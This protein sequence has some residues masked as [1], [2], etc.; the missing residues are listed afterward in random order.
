MTEETP[1]SGLRAPIAQMFAVGAVASAL[2]IGL[3]LLIDWWPKQGST[4]S[5]DIDTLYDVLIIVTVP[6]FVMVT[7]IV[8]FSCLTFRMRPGEE[9][10]DGPPTHGNTRLEVIWTTIPAL[11]LV[12]MC[13]YAY[14]VL[15]DIE[16]A[17]AGE[18][19]VNV[20]G[21]QFTWKFE[22]PATEKGGKPVTSAELYLPKDK[23]VRFYVESLDVIHDFWVPQFRM[24][25]D[26]VPGIT[27]KYRIT[28]ERSGKYPVVCAELCGP[29]HSFMRQSAHVVSPAAF[30]AW[31]KK[32]TMPNRATGG[33]A[34]TIDAKSLFA[35]SGCNGCHTLADAQASGTT[36]PDLDKVL[37][38]QSAAEIKA[39]IA[40]PAA[41]V[42]AGFPNVM[43][44]D[45]ATRLSPEELDAL[46]KYLTEVAGK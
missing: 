8:L 45:Y 43:P 26:A 3:G 27:T 11:M 2:G 33:D 31:K 14:V 38:G 6:I 5:K 10:L 42:T 41:K 16:D 23:P 21:Q 4:Q 44:T 36:G 39:S 32:Q 7:V 12:I 30:A 37:P 29:G 9:E 46:V 15:T 19:R 1:R 28:P 13:S 18:I 22:Y 35:S 20:T 17:K 34:E 24:K 25:V 40:M